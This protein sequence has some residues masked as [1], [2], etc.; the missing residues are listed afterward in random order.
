MYRKTIVI[1]TI[2]LVSFLLFFTYRIGKIEGNV[3][4]QEKDTIINN[5]K[6]QI[7]EYDTCTETLIKIC[8]ERYE[9]IEKRDKLIEKSLKA[10]EQCY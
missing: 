10:L 2:V 3:S 8:E 4:C 9:Q 6:L 1:T 7:E 5:L